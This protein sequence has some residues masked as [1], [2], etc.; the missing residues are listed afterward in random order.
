MTVANMRAALDQLPP[1]AMLAPNDVGNL[2]VYHPD[3]NNWLGYID[4]C[5]EKL[6]LQDEHLPEGD[7]L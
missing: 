7:P 3:F 4:I 5:A 1:D 6:W 2:S